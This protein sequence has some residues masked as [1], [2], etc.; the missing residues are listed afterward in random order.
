MGEADQAMQ[1]LT[2]TRFEGLLCQCLVKKTGDEL[3]R[4][5]RQYTA[6][7]SEIIKREWQGALCQHVVGA[8]T[9]HLS[10]SGAPA[11]APSSSVAAGAPKEKKEKKKD[12]KKEGKKSK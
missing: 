8:V 1:D 5:L 3:V 11:D 10:G 12:G 6:E 9:P 2:I 4:K 7:C